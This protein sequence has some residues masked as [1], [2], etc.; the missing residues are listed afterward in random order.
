MS[1]IIIHNWAPKTVTDE[2]AVAAVLEV[3]KDGRI[4][5]DGRHYCYRTWIKPDL[6]VQAK[7]NGKGT[8]T[9]CVYK[10]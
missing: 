10:D 6:H 1:K 7:N 4:S 5:G 9:F 3:I 8:D 2:E